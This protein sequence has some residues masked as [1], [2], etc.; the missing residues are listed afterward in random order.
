MMKK[1]IN[2]SDNHSEAWGE[3][4]RACRFTIVE[5]DDNSPL[6]MEGGI[7]TDEQ[8]KLLSIL[9]DDIGNVISPNNTKALIFPRDI[10]YYKDGVN[11]EKILNIIR[12]RESGGRIDTGNIMGFIGIHDNNSEHDIFI[13]IRSR[14]DTD[15]VK[16]GK[17]EKKSKK[18]D[19]SRTKAKDYFMHYLLQ[20]VMCINIMNLNYAYDENDDVF[21]FYT[22]LLPGMLKSAMKQGLFKMYVRQEFNDPKVKGTIDVNRHIRKNIP[23]NGKVAYTAREHTTDNPLMQLVRHAIEELKSR[24]EGRSI[25]NSD[26]EVKEYVKLIEGCTNGY[27]AKD[28]DL[29]LQQNLKPLRHPYYTEYEPLRKLCNMILLKN[30]LKFAEDAI[31]DNNKSIYGILFD[32]AWLWEEYIANILERASSFRLPEVTCQRIVH[33]QNKAK[34]NPIYVFSNSTSVAR[35]PD[36]YSEDGTFVMDAKYK[37][38]KPETNFG[39][40]DRNDLNQMLTYMYILGKE[41]QRGIFIFPIHESELKDGRTSYILDVEGRGG[42]ISKLAF[43]IPRECDT[44]EEFKVMMENS[45]IEFIKEFNKIVTNN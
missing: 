7:L 9:T 20:K 22:Y 1:L 40:I 8:V 44:F 4:G 5:Q 16:S 13:R 43:V 19:K 33:P 10:N 31:R 12:D 39:D 21:D 6:T 3:N 15:Y 24:P 28:R 42:K 26:K 36:Y 41:C 18:K 30:R 32:G 2:L 38:I 14:F 45:E 29:I 35:Y 11:Q 27:R 25:L 34:A 23:F 17:E 37:H